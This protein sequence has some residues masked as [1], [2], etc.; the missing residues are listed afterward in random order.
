MID[1]I[2]NLDLD[3]LRVRL[4]HATAEK[5]SYAAY[6]QKI[7]EEVIRRYNERL[8]AELRGKDE[9]FGTIKLDGIKFTVPKKV[10]W[11]QSALANLYT[12]IGDTAHEYMD[13]SYKV[14]E[15]AFKNWPS[16]IQD[17]FIPARTV[18]PGTINIE[19][20]TEE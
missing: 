16:S 7:K 11:D 2:S 20:T 17:A 13:V 15:A 12:E 1:D 5:K 14:K 3:E 19:F 18:R 6:E 10:D 8:A 9:P 4:N